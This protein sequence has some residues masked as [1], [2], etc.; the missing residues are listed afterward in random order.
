MTIRSLNKLD[1]SKIDTLPDGSWSDGASLYLVVRNGGRLKSW[2]FRY[3]I[4]G[5]TR[6]MGLGA[7]CAVPLADARAKRDQLRK[8]IDE[9]RDPLDER[10]K[11]IA[12]REAQAK[13]ERAAQ[14]AKQPFK[15]VAEAV[16]QRKR[17]GWKH[18]KEGTSY[19]AWERSLMV[20]A[21]ALHAL[22]ISE[23]TVDDVEKAVKPKWD[24]KHHVE[25]RL[26]L[27]RLEAVFGYAASRGMRTAANPAMWSTFKH[28]A[29]A[30]PKGAKHH[31][32]LAWQDA[33]AFMTELLKITT[34]SALALE[35]L[36]LTGVRLNEACK[37]EWS[38]ID[39]ERALWTIPEARMKRGIEH[40][41]PLS[42]RAMAILRALREHSGQGRYVFPGRKRKPIS[43]AA[44]K[45]VCRR[46]SGRKASPHGWRATC[47]S[48]MADHAMPFDLAESMLA[49]S[50]GSVVDA[51][52]RASMA[53]LRRPWMQRWADHL[54]GK[55]P[56]SAEP[57]SA[58]IIPLIPLARRTA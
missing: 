37:A 24:A 29:P 52:M 17:D 19:A 27:N 23:I 34:V 16:L 7:L 20:D 6:E 33:P 56:V 58:E 10:R 28:I 3:S 45:V 41:V 18:G 57:A 9:G 5:R 49:H 12:Q 22:P 35:F 8:L 1:P 21:K 26:M 47:R 42:D 48:F 51:Y 25:G 43:D 55:E 50:R 36:I 39:F 30:K 46:L 31:P 53:E 13:A 14:A 40:V 15:E 11:M 44:L 32:S 54:D 2:I 38:E 4:G